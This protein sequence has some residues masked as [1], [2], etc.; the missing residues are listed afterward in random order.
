MLR[1]AHGSAE[2]LGAAWLILRACKTSFVETRSH[3]RGGS[4][5]YLMTGNVLNAGSPGTFRLPSSTP[6]R[7][8]SA[9]SCAVTHY[10][11]VHRTKRP[12]IV[13]ITRDRQ[14]GKCVR[15]ERVALRTTE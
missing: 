5:G 13:V 8:T 15:E 6:F 2:T 12:I 11:L 1:C 10:E 7:A 14:P 9:S 3:S 4:A